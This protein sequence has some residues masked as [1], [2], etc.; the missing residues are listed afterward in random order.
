MN[1]HKD[2]K[3]RSSHFATDTDSEC[4]IENEEHT[5]WGDATEDS[6]AKRNRDERGIPSSVASILRNRET[7]HQGTE[8]GVDRQDNFPELHS[9]IKKELNTMLFYA[10][11]SGKKIS[12]EAGNLI[13]SKKIG[14]LVKA[15]SI[16]CDALA[17]ATPETVTYINKFYSENK[18][19]IIFSPIPLVRNFTFMAIIA[20]IGIIASS[21]SPEV[22]TQ[23]LSKGVL[24]NHGLSLLINLVFLSSASLMG[25][26]FFL[27]SKLTRAVKEATLSPE[28][29]TYYWAMLIM[30]V[31]SGMILS[32][33]VSIQTDVLNGSVE[34]NRLIFAILGGFSSEIVYKI[35]Q[36]IMQKIQSMIAAL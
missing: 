14:D 5:N 15:H 18:K 11:H 33:G 34:T 32:E 7:P 16:I 29:T 13:P 21:L 22:N 9:K 17:P 1:I 10:L 3:G 24:N 35:L 6:D 12:E 31:L 23:T 8:E 27:L 20:I 28:D 26:V 2:F 30:G 19:F 25:A 4:N 36:S